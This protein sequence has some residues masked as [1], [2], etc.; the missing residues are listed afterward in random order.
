MENLENSNN[1]SKS[2]LLKQYYKPDFKNLFNKIKG[3]KAPVKNDILMSLLDGQWHSETELIRIAKKQQQYLGS[4]TL[5]TMVH[6]LNQNL[7]NN[8]VQKQN[9]NGEMYY[10]ITDNY[11]GLTRAAYTK[12][13]FSI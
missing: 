13:R 9:I 8:Y 5:G 7:A 10:K 11:I 2:A 6:L 1:L 4:V 3:S 12:Y